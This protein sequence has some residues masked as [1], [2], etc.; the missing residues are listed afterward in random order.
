MSTLLFKGKAHTF[1]RI[2]LKLVHIGGYMKTGKLFQYEGLSSSG[3]TTIAKRINAKMIEMGLPA[4]F[5]SEPTRITPFGLGIREVIE[6]RMPSSEL[7]DNISDQ[8]KVLFSF[9]DK[10]L[11]NSESSQVQTWLGRFRGMVESIPQHIKEGK[12]LT[13]EEK[14]YMYICDRFFNFKDYLIPGIERGEIRNNDRGDISSLSIGAVNGLGLAWNAAMHR[15]VLGEF[16]RKPDATIV[17]DVPPDVCFQRSIQLKKVL[18]CYES[19]EMQKK[20]HESLKKTLEYL[21]Q[22]EI[23]FPGTG[24]KN[25]IVID[26]TPPPDVVDE[27]IFQKLRETGVLP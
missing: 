27:M 24:H 13:E 15:L 20:I 12:E 21:R 1:V 4:V 10:T 2:H 16:Y 26:A 19:A 5:S 18:D 22:R 25:I 11:L 17:F 3:K 6:R 14:Q 23:D 9:I 8:T 7:L